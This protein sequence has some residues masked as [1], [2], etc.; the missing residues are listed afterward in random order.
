MA[1]K[2]RMRTVRAYMC[3]KVTWAQVLKVGGRLSAGVWESQRRGFIVIK[4]GCC[5]EGEGGS[6][7][8][9]SSDSLLSCHCPPPTPRSSPSFVL[10]M[11][12]FFSEACGM[13]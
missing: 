12:P 9:R 6:G 7:E 10:G 5:E 4:I 1:G 8:G 11:A 3:R 2:D 13:V